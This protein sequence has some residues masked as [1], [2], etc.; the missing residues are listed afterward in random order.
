MW[1]FG[2]TRARPGGGRCGMERETSWYSIVEEMD[3]G[4]RLL[5]LLLTE[6]GTDPK[7]SRRIREVYCPPSTNFLSLLP[8]VKGCGR[9]V[10]G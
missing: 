2:E 1:G 4:D 8:R 5:R 3:R 10:E 7:E 9:E 6:I